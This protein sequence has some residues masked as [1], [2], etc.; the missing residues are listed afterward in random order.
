MVVSPG[1]L[2]IAEAKCLSKVCASLS[3]AC[4]L[5]PLPVLVAFVAFLFV[6]SA[7]LE[8]AGFTV[9]FDAARLCVVR[10]TIQKCSLVCIARHARVRHL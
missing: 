3:G 10:V 5:H 9:L 7:T 8:Y 1:E 2:G 4:L 6:Y